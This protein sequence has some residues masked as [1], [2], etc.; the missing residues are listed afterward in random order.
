MYKIS[1]MPYCPL[2]SCYTNLRKDTSI[3]FRVP[4]LKDR[5]IGG[6]APKCATIPSPSRKNIKALLDLK[7]YVNKFQH[8]QWM[9][10]IN[11]ESSD[12]H[13]EYKDPR[14]C[15]HRFHPSTHFKVAS[16]TKLLPGT[17]PTINVTKD[18]LT[19]SKKLP[20]FAKH[21]S[22]VTRS[23]VNKDKEGH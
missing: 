22:T 10:V 11:K 21:L 20:R 12:T 5:H 8:Y 14:I 15:I 18:C 19:E 6:I 17:C 3:C 2:L 9:K 16:T 23:Y 4:N 13:S 1:I 7:N